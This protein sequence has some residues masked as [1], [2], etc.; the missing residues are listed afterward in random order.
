MTLQRRLAPVA[1]ASIKGAAA[2]ADLALRPA[3]GITIL[4]YHRVG[5]G[6][7]GQMD[8]STQAFEAQLDWLCSAGSLSLRIISVAA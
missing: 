8:L 6:D 5:A 7:G 3:A 4:I 2:V 1:R